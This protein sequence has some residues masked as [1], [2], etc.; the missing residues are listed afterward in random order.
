M[1]Q[2]TQSHVFN[3]RSRAWGALLSQSKLQDLCS[4]CVCLCVFVCVIFRSSKTVFCLS[5]S[6]NINENIQA[7]H[8]K[9]TVIKHLP[10]SLIVWRTAQRQFQVSAGLST[11]PWIRSWRPVGE[12][13]PLIERDC[14]KLVSLDMNV[15]KTIKQCHK[16]PMTG[17]VFFLFSHLFMVKL[18]MVYD[19][20]LTTL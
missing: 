17:N 3:S 4:V 20:V 10:K 8:C 6:L 11:D 15:G 2:K 16:R 12:G 18:W 5:T 19:M 1:S 14:Y 13:H 7:K 9:T